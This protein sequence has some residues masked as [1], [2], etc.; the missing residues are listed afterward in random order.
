MFLKSHLEENHLNYYVGQEN[1]VE[2]S[3]IFYKDLLCITQI[4]VGSETRNYKKNSNLIR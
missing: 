2:I 4:N 1:Y 3:T